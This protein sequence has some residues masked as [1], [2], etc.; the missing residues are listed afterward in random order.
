MISVIKANGIAEPFNESKVVSSIKRAH[1]PPQLEGDVL[2]RVKAKL[3][4]NIP[5]SEIYGTIMDSLGSSQQ[6]YT[7][8]SYSLKQSLMM[9]GPTGYPFEDYVGKILESRG[10][11]TVVRQVLRG[12]CVSHE[13]DVIAEKNGKRSMIE[14]KFHNNPGTRS[15]V[16]V[17]LYTHARF[18][19]LKDKYEF[20]DAWIVTNTKTTTDAVAYAECI[21]MKTLSWSYPLEG[22][23]R[24]LIESAE[25]HPVTMLTSLSSAHK[26]KLLQHHIVLCRDLQENPSYLEFLRLTPEERKRTIEE[27]HFIA[28]ANLKSSPDTPQ[29]ALL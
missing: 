23:L 7:K 5:T 26:L 20:D 4:N 2:K 16:H 1:I 25:L 24:E 10:Y 13:I 9:L 19:D 6:P 11:K 14:A 17:A 15:D 28:K 18:L 8:A 12:K 3:Y 22:S 27:L 29:Q 21:G